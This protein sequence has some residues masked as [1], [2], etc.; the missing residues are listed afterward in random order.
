MYFPRKS[1]KVE[2]AT[3]SVTRDGYRKRLKGKNVS[4]RRASDRMRGRE[5][6]LFLQE[7][8]EALGVAIELDDLS[9]EGDVA[10]ACEAAHDADHREDEELDDVERKVAAEVRPEECSDRHLWCERDSEKRGTNCFSG[11][12]A[13]GGKRAAVNLWRGSRHPT[14]S[15]QSRHW[16]AKEGGGKMSRGARRQEK[17]D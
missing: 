14:A 9:V 2:E 3:T 8:V 4:D 12:E 15:R 11:K 13:K 10:C 16:N 6:G 1:G 5:D 7:F 17:Q